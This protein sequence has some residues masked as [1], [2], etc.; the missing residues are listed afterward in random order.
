MRSLFISL[1]LSPEPFETAPERTLAYGMLVLFSLAPDQHRQDRD[2]LARHAAHAGRA[3]ST[4]L[5]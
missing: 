3:G 2:K 4:V 5:T 1:L